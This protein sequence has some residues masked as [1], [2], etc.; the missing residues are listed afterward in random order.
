M[1]RRAGCFVGVVLLLFVGAATALVW[2]VLSATGAVSSPPFAIA[3]SGI[4]VVLG[5]VAVVGAVFALRRLAAPIGRL[6]E[7]AQRVEAGDYSARVP[8]KGPPEVRS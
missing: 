5:I 7:G 6:I 2:L 1:L 4:A 8:V 3:I